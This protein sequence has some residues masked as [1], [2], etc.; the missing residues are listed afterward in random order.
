MRLANDT[1]WL[2]NEL[3]TESIDLKNNH[4]KLKNAIAER[5]QQ[6][7]PDIIKTLSENR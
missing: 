2:I 3:G 7:M 4:I 5:L 1:I 6:I